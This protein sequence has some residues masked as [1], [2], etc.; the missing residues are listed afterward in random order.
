[1]QHHF[2]PPQTLEEAGHRILALE[3]EVA[4]VW[5]FLADIY[6]RPNNPA[7]ATELLRRINENGTPIAEDAVRN[8]R[9]LASQQ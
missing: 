5:A 2:I 8:L 1:M 6:A 9:Q 7:M 4:S 3:S